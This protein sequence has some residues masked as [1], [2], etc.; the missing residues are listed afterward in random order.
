LYN[1]AGELEWSLTIPAAA[2]QDQWPVQVPAGNRSAGTYTLAVHGIVATGESKDLG[3]AS[4]DLQI[5][6]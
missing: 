6:Q 1:P 2:S 4:F 5:Q 3:R